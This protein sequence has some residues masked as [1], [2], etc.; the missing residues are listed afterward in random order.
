M[1]TE[2]NV[3]NLHDSNDPKHPLTYEFLPNPQKCFR[4]LL[5]SPSN[6]G[7]SNL[8]KSLIIRK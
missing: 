7:K 5:F 6:S 8:I 3:I 4:M 2:L 1:A